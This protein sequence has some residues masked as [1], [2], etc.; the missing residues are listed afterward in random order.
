M[1]KAGQRSPEYSGDLG[2]DPDS[3]MLENIPPSVKE[4]LVRLQ[5]ENKRLRAKVKSRSAFL[6]MQIRNV[7]PHK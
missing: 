5:R 1:L 4:R 7:K 6:N 2:D 3:G